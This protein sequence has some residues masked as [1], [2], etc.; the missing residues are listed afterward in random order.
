[1]FFF[2]AVFN[3][4]SNSPQ[5]INYGKDECEHCRM[6]ITDNRYGAEIVTDKGKIYKFD[7]VECL[8]E[9]ALAENLIG[10]DQQTFLVTNFSI[11]EKL[12]NSETAFYIHNDNL[13]SPMG[14]NVSAVS[15]KTELENFLKEN[16]GRELTWI[17]V[18]EMV[19]QNSM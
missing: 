4:C 11:P 12:I 13:R 3:A 16:G 6:M 10:D 15:N 7:A 14:L 1:M 5:P 17:E 8:I 19:K 2:I 18:I 9:F